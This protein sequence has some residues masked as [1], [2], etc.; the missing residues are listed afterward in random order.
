[1]EQ[2]RRIE[3]GMKSPN[4]GYLRARSLRHACDVLGEYDGE[5]VAIAGGQS[6]LAGLNMRLSSPRLLVDIGGLPE[7]SRFRISARTRSCSV[8]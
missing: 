7:L 2:T 6:L 4:F 3:S 5:A 8:L 1:M